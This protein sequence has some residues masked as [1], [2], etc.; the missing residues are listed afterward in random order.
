MPASTSRLLQEKELMSQQASL[1][2]TVR[3]SSSR[4]SMKPSERQ[5][6]RI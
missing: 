4:L 1:D 2:R 6:V 3:N 5:R